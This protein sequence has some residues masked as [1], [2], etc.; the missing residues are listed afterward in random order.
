VLILAHIRDNFAAAFFPRLSEW[1]CAMAVF[2]VGGVSF[3]NLQ[4]L[5]D[6]SLLPL[7]PG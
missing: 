1:A 5:S 7:K 2:G 6:V 4:P 3:A